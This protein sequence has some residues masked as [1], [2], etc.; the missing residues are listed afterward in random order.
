MAFGAPSLGVFIVFCMLALVGVCGGVL[1]SWL[2]L[3]I[4]FFLIAAFGFL[5]LFITN[6]WTYFLP[7]RDV[8]KWKKQ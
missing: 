7:D 4:I 8:S 3:R 2:W 1:S 6:A 5:L